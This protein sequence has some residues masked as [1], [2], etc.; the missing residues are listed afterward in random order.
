MK[1]QKKN[2]PEQKPDAVDS[3]AEQVSEV[4]GQVKA[5]AVADDEAAPAEAPEGA[6]RKHCSG[7]LDCRCAK[8][9]SY[10]WLEDIP[11]GYAESDLVEVQFKN[12]RKGYYRNSTNLPLEVGDMVAVEASPGHD[13][14]MVTL[15]GKLVELRMRKAE[16]SRN[17]QE[18]RRV[19]RKARP[20]DME[21]YQEARARE[22]DTMIKARRIADDLNLNMK[23][24][25]V[26][27]QGDGNKAI[28][29]Y[30]ADERVDFRQ[31]IKVLA[32][33]FKV[34]I[35][36]KQ[37]GARQEAGRIGGIGPCGRPLCCSQWMTNFVSVATNAARHQDISLN[38]QKLAGQCAKL[39][40]C[41]NFEVNTYIEASK[42]MPSKDVRLE[43]ADATYFHFKTDLFKRLITYSTDK[44]VPAN[45]VTI[46][47]DRVFE[48]IELNRNGQKPL[49]LEPDGEKKEKPKADFGDIL[50]G[51][52]DIS[53]FD[54]K[55][56]KRKKGSK[57]GGQNGSKAAQS[58]GN[59]GQNQPK[60]NQNRDN[61][62]REQ[63]QNKSGKPKD[64]NQRRRPKPNKENRNEE[65][66]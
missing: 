44:N 27:Y 20:A 10:N 8:L 55:K 25:D 52:D 31:L 14:G 28:F 53:R 19:F 49:S 41:L 32:E 40:C 61:Q 16:G 46:S 15:T 60:E 45:L 42:K 39:K 37:I 57:G 62:S 34:R 21:K 26:E 23:I 18:I 63:K 2:R 12:T 56:R 65:S 11:G 5:E 22:D 36:M 54:K 29:Y 66:D 48:I 4:A 43:T 64:K 47:A 17:Q 33:T 38:P 50:G 9:H 51:E 30:I 24:G 3:T 35:E 1:H 58:D 6:P 7:S 13:I 59:Q